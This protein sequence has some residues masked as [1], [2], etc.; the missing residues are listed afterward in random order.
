MEKCFIEDF[1]L[2]KSMCDQEIISNAEL[3]VG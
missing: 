2:L 1:S 3:T